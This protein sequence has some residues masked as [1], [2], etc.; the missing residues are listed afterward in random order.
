MG[1]NSGMKMKARCAAHYDATDGRRRWERHAMRR[2]PHRAVGRE[3]GVTVKKH[4]RNPA[5]QVRGRHESRVT[6]GGGT[7]Q[8]SMADAIVQIPTIL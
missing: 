4:S 2:T 5:Q 6:C 7:R 8:E 3:T 1:C